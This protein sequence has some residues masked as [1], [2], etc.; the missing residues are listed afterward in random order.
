MTTRAKFFLFFQISLVLFMVWVLGACRPCLPFMGE[1]DRSNALL[2]RVRKGQT[3]LVSPEN[4]KRE[5][6]KEEVLLDSGTLLLLADAVA[7]QKDDDMLTIIEDNANRENRENGK[8]TQYPPPPHQKFSDFTLSAYNHSLL[9]SNKKSLYVLD[10]AKKTWTKI[11]FKPDSRVWKD[12]DVMVFKEPIFGSK[13]TRLVLHRPSQ[14]SRQAEDRILV[15]TPS[16]IYDWD[17]SPGQDTVV[18]G[19]PGIYIHYKSPTKEWTS[20][21]GGYTKYD[22]AILPQGRVWV[23]TTS[24]MHTDT[25]VAELNSDGQFVGWRARGGHFTEME[26]EEMPIE[27]SENDVKRIKKAIAP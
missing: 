24:M 17:Y 20:S 22:V 7:L 12:S 1:V 14:G 18:W 11:P 5:N 3:I 10:R 9:A 23:M 15:E 8:V 2:I 27:L 19:G 4:K 6:N 26:L 13:G 16:A 21:V 25:G